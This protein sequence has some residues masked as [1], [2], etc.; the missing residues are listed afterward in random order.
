MSFLQ[1]AQNYWDFIFNTS[2]FGGHSLLD[3]CLLNNPLLIC[4][5]LDQSHPISSR[6]SP[7]SSP[8]L[9]LG[10]SFILSAKDSTQNVVSTILLSSIQATCSIH[11]MHN[12]LVY[13]TTSAPPIIWIFHAHRHFL[14]TRSVRILEEGSRRY[15]L[16]RSSRVPPPPQR[17]TPAMASRTVGG[18]CCD[19]PT[20]S[21]HSMRYQ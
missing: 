20:S 8:N 13:L 17:S 12:D 1:W 4:S 19:V 2:F 5:L 14:L 9:L 16:P 18:H 6:S 3:F 15:L 10:L 21:V 11:A 7:T